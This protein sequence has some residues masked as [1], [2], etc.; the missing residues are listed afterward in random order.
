MKQHKAVR[1]YSLLSVAILLVVS[2]LVTVWSSSMTQ[3]QSSSGGY[4]LTPLRSELTIERGQSA[5]VELSVRNVTGQEAPA[6]VNLLD[7]VPNPDESGAAKVIVDREAYGDNPFSLLEFVE[8][9]DAKLV[10]SDT[11]TAFKVRVS[12]PETAAPGSYF[13]VLQ[14]GPADAA[15]LSGEDGGGAVGL[16]ATVGSLLL[17]TVPGDTVELITLEELS[18][19]LDGKLSNFFSTKPDT[20]ALRLKNEGNVFSKPFGNIIVKSMGGTVIQDVE[21]NNTSPPGNV[22][23]D[24][25]R[26]FEIPLEGVGSFGRYTVEANVSYGDGSSVITASETF[27]VLPWVPIVIGLAVIITLL[28]GLTRG[29]KAYNQ[30][31]LRRSKKVE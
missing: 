4:R 5:E 13:G 6:G 31:V 16:S 26:K 11:D 12:I 14:V 10:N 3:A 21:F 7:F 24:S 27:W 18:A 25:I 15:D 28:F 20:L 1:L 19:S 17:V 8:L 30:A 23:P 29:V 9:P 22:L 2:L